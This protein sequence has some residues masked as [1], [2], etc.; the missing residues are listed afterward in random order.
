MPDPM[1]RVVSRLLDRE[2][3]LEE[4]LRALE[5][6]LPG[7]GGEDARL[8]LTREDEVRNALRTVIDP[9]VGIDVV[10]LGLIR[11]IHV[12][13]RT[14]A[15]TVDLVLTTKGCPLVDYLSEQ[16]RRRTASLP[17]ITD[18]R[19]PGARRALGLG[20]VPEPIGAVEEGIEEEKRA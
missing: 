15:A 10:D 5:R 4:R 13:P 7:P 19:G 2:N 18:G 9:E 3:Q 16:V 17:G 6:A 20:A 12:D 8:E 11:E 14:G 1:L